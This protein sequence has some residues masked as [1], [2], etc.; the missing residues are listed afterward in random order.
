MT[1]RNLAGR[2]CLV[3]VVCAAG[4]GVAQAGTPGG[5]SITFG[6]DAAGVPALGSVALALLAGLLAF[7]GF[8]AAR[9][10]R[11]PALVAC[12]GVSA[13]I[14]AAGSAELVRS[15][16][17]STPTTFIKNQEKKTFPLVEGLNGFQN[18]SGAPLNVLA[19]DP[20]TCSIGSTG[21]DCTVGQTLAAGE[22]CDVN[23]TCFQESDRRL[24]TAIEQIGTTVHGLPLYRFSY[25][26]R[27]GRFEGVM[28]Q[29]VLAV[30]PEAVALR[31][32]GYYAVDYGLL[33]APF[34]RV[35]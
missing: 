15:V 4:I 10:R 12:L 20:G 19:I 14:A 3:A 6:P 16:S 24:K 30:M 23:L 26:D 29:D 18:D 22:L 28:A 5:G 11:A 21:Q 17:A 32:N 2:V 31:S 35:R 33:G 13:A 27:P 9:Q 1:S 7:M 34:R 8:R 25:R